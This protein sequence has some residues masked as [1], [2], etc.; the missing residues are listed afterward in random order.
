ML[1]AWK[2]EKIRRAIASMQQQKGATA[3]ATRLKQFT[4]NYHPITPLLIRLWSSLCRDYVNDRLNADASETDQGCM[5]DREGTALVTYTF[6]LHRLYSQQISSL[7]V[8]EVFFLLG[9][10]L[11]L[12]RKS[13]ML[14]L[15]KLD[16]TLQNCI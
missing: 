11:L 1:K 8:A 5:N 10:I 2:G 7:E 4:F 3:N 12:R 6:T 14:N 13:G 9:L 15:N 16:C